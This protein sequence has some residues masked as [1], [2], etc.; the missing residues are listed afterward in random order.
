M[1]CPLWRLLFSSRSVNKHGHHRQFLFDFL[2][3]VHLNGSLKVNCYFIVKR[4]LRGAQILIFWC[5]FFLLLLNLLCWELLVVCLQISSI[6]Y[7]C[8]KQYFSYIVAFSFIGGGTGVPGENHRPAA[9]HW[10]TLLH[11]VVHLALIEIR[12]SVVIGTDCIGSCK[13]N[14]HMIA[15]TTA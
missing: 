11:N 2:Q 1:E 6:F 14:Y 5:V 12:T 8:L 3:G 7:A 15:A 10:Q 13:S 4:G 9:S